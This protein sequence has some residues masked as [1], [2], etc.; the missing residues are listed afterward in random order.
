MYSFLFFLNLSIFI[1]KSDIREEERQRGRSSVRWFTPQVSTTAGAE[2]IQSQEPG[3]SSRSPTWVQGSK[4]L[5]LPQLCSQATSRELDGKRGRQNRSQCPYGIQ[6]MHG[7]DLAIRLSYMTPS[8]KFL[9]LLPF[10][11]FYVYS[12]A[13]SLKFHTDIYNLKFHIYTH[14]YVHI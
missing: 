8:Y 6:H 9:C 1:G 10:P 14:I 3:V 4:A 13:I 2:P 5:C 12:Q 11:C 7:E